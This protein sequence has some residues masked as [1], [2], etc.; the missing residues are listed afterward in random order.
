MTL[1]AYDS[2]YKGSDG[3]LRNTSYNGHFTGNVLGGADFKLRKDGKF[4]LGLNGKVTLAGGKRYT[5]IDPVLSAQNNSTYFIDSLAWTA[6]T[7]PYFRADFR[8]SF[9][10]NG[11]KV[12]QEIAVDISNIL[13]TQNVLF[14]T[15]DPG[16]ARVREV[17]QLGR[18]PI[19]QYKI[20]F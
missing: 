5:P 2:K 14:L 15:Y 11:K 10:I 7:K 3:V 9:R 13:N 12:S 16:T 4:I 1:S 8:T 19:I 18:L 20:E 6:Q 17:Y